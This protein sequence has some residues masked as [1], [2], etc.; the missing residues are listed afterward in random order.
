MINI[1]EKDIM[2]MN[3]KLI[4]AGAKEKDVLAIV[5][6]N[7]RRKSEQEIYAH[8]KS[9]KYAKYSTHPVK[10]NI[11]AMEGT[12]VTELKHATKST[13]AGIRNAGN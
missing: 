6:Q 13:C 2:I 1:K 8:S 12:V 3:H 5:N 7:R 10:S 9:K 11:F 4:L